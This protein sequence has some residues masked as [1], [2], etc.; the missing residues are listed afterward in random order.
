MRW[1]G[2]GLALDMFEEIK[3]FM[4]EQ[5]QVVLGYETRPR[6]KVGSK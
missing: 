1:V 6:A 3:S 2:A 4:P 5:P